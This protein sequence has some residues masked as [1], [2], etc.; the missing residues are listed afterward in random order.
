MRILA[1]DDDPDILKF[2]KKALESHGHSVDT[3]DTAFGLVNLVSGI[4]KDGQ[5]QRPDLL[6]LDLA[7]PGL[8]G[9]ALLDLLAQN[10]RTQDVPVL[11]FSALPVEDIMAAAS[12]HPRCMA[13]EKTGHINSILQAAQR[14]LQ[15][16]ATHGAPITLPSDRLGDERIAL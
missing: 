7:L 10:S 5:A 14:L 8:S 15:T 13:L 1:V 9:S 6:I 11:L 4:A 16:P 12:R 3:R 2:L